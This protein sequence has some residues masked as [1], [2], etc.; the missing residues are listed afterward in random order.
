MVP[1][2]IRKKFEL[3]PGDSITWEEK[4]DGTVVVK[5]KKRTSLDDVVGMIAVGGDAVADRPRTPKKQDAEKKDDTRKAGT[6][7]SS[8]TP[9]T[10][11]T[12]EG[13]D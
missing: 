7:K 5:P 8:T 4:R 12:P 6:A 9:A 3:V 2:E 10:P 11:E 1:K 13:K